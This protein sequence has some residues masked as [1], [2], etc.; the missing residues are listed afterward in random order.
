MKRCALF[1]CGLSFFAGACATTHTARST[2]DKGRFERVGGRKLY[3]NGQHPRLGRLPKT[4]VPLAVNDHVLRWIDYFTGSPGARDQFSRYLQR[5]GR[6]LDL[7]RAELRRQGMPEDLVYVALIE[8]GFRN[9]AHS[10]ASAVGTWQFIRATGQRYGLLINHHID[11][12]R[13]PEKAVGAAAKYLKDLYNEF[14]DWYLAMAG[15]NAG[16]GRVRQAIR[17]YGNRDFWY[18]SRQRNAFRPETRDYVPKYIAA[19]IIASDPARFGIRHVSYDDPLAYDAATIRGQVPLEA[20]AEACGTPF[21][22][23]ADLNAELYGGVTPPGHYQVRLP[24]GTAK[25]FRSRFARVMKNYRD[26]PVTQTQFLRYRIRRGDSLGRIANRHRV[27]V[28]RLMAVN[29]LHSPR[30]LRAGRVLNIPQTV[31]VRRQSTATLVS[32][33][34]N[35]GP[36]ITRGRQPTETIQVAMSQEPLRQPSSPPSSIE[37]IV[38]DAEAADATVAVSSQVEPSVE[39]AE[40]SVSTMYRVRR[41][42]SLARV[43]HKTGVTVGELR[44]WNGLPDN[45]LRV[46]QLL[47]LQER[48]GARARPVAA[49]PAPVRITEA[50]PAPQALRNSVARAVTPQK[51]SAAYAV[52][53]GDS[54]YTI[55]RRHGV[56]VSDLRRWNGGLQGN[57]LRVGQKLSLQR[58]QLAQ[59]V[60][61]RAVAR[62]TASRGVSA[63]ADAK[64]IRYR[65]QPGD[66]LWDISQVYKVHP[67]Q[68]KKWNNM[69]HPLIKP[70]Q[71]LTILVSSS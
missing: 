64:A 62:T 68:I 26:H 35:A 28:R 5:S 30:H 11:E 9:Q 3:D 25:A 42:D 53:R 43:A 63:I 52:R 21:E 47:A 38:R 19:T 8:S 29:R 65:V 39:P 14:G 61:P 24:A 18:L 56:T 59:T 70:G 66:T 48:N 31:R 22:T 2:Y 51:H 27:S 16:E 20:V 71:R 45:R 34:A 60:A 33:A 57:H 50:A 49:T 17:N 36:A 32:V 55:A 54:L 23:I 46:G 6:Y 40:P 69:K 1:L 15:Y 37:E 10:H 7:M 12:R 13:D 58:G 44:R 41:G 67:D 4:D